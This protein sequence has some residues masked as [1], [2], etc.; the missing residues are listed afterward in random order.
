MDST[1]FSYQFSN[2]LSIFT[3]GDSSLEEDEDSDDEYRLRDTNCSSLGMFLESADTSAMERPITIG[4][5]VGAENVNLIHNGM[6][7]VDAKQTSKESDHDI[8]K[9]IHTGAKNQHRLSDS[10][11]NKYD[12]E[13]KA[14]QEFL[15][16]YN[17]NRSSSND[18]EV[19]NTNDYVSYM[20]TNASSPNAV[21]NTFLSCLQTNDAHLANR[22]LRDIGIEYI[23]RHCLVYDGIFTTRKVADSVDGLSTQTSCTN[24]F[25]LCSFFG[26]ADVLEIMIEECWIFFV[27]Q[28]TGGAIE[29][30]KEVQDRADNALALLLNYD[31]ESYGCTPLFIAAAQD[32][33]SVI[34]VLLKHKVDPNAAN[35]IG[36]TAASIAA[37]MDNLAVLEALG[38]AKDAD[39]DFNQ[40]NEDGITPLLAAC[41]YGSV[42]CVR[43]LT[44]YMGHMGHAS[45]ST[46]K[47]IVNCKVQD[48]YGLGCTAVAAKHNNYEV[49][50]YFCQINNPNIEVGVNINQVTRDEHNTALHVAAQY[51]SKEAAKSLLQMIPREI[52]PL[53]RNKRG[54]T[55]LH[56]A[57]SRGHTEIVKEFVISLRDGMKDLDTADSVGM[58]PLFYGE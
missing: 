14:I 58:T 41:Q 8:P 37:S 1:V 15:E 4:K 11:V 2:D 31:V 10:E 24:M 22:L 16:R 46:G 7:K 49:V 23:I 34:K 28:E 39:V 9:N 38:E 19:M 53:R 35:G 6:L 52:D 25:W 13:L 57:A 27:E 45:S 47:P 20:E 3:S 36:T 12:Q 29:P 5:K 26:S 51:N 33:A 55:A 44:H 42:E 43:Y 56:I 50:A 40:A 18:E 32:H 30:C 17:K 48:K 21:R 54:M